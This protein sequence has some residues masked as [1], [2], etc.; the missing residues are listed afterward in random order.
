[1]Y[2][3]EEAIKLLEEKQEQFISI[4]HIAHT[5]IAKKV[6]TLKRILKYY[7]IEDQSIDNYISKTEEIY[8]TK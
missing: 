8:K 2:S 7:E 5:S 1:V 6:E 4:I 3:R